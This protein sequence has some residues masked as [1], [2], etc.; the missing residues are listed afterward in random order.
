MRSHARRSQERP[1]GRPTAAATSGD[2]HHPRRR[3]EVRRAVR[4]APAG[5]G[6]ARGE[7]AT[8]SERRSPFQPGADRITRPRRGDVGVPRAAGG[9]AQV[10]L[11]PPGAQADRAATS[12]RARR[13]PPRPPSR[14]AGGRAAARRIL[15]A[16]APLHRLEPRNFRLDPRTHA[17]ANETIVPAPGDPAYRW[18]SPE[19]RRRHLD[20]PW[21]ARERVRFL[22]PMH[23]EWFLMWWDQ[24][25]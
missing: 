1:A 3:R 19:F 21:M 15:V 22:G 13:S 25:V 11:P 18:I 5:G 14:G 6:S 10:L 7:I 24:T 23:A 16:R 17:P 2:L 4:R 20:L 9:A 8:S 12:A